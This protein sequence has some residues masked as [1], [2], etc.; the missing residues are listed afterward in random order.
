[1]QISFLSCLPAEG[2]RSVLLVREQLRQLFY[3]GYADQLSQLFTCRRCAKRS[4]SS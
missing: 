2:A 4:R 1:M 3:N